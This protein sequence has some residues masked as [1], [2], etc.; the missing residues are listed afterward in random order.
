MPY[1][2]GLLSLLLTLTLVLASQVS[3]A[4]W[5]IAG[6]TNED[7]QNIVIV[8]SEKLHRNA[9]RTCLAV[10]LARS[11]AVN[12]PDTSNPQNVT[13]FA[14]LDGVAL[15]I[16]RFVKS[17][18]FKCPQADGSE[19]SL[20]ENLEKFLELKGGENNLVLCP[21]CYR[22]RFDDREPD[23]GVLPGFNAPGS[24]VIDVLLNADKVIDF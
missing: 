17:R 22:E 23:Y 1:R 14:T 19:I 9:E 5:S 4:D 21:I 11:L 24:A 7:P 20:K 13:I 8:V 3:V 18:R 16:R 12:P 2:Y 15:G 6:P 10:T